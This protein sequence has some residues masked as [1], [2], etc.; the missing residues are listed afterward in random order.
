[1]AIVHRI[2]GELPRIDPTAIRAITLQASPSGAT[3]AIDAV[4]NGEWVADVT[5]HDST[6][7]AL[8]YLKDRTE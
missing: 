3:L 7:S 6:E 8:A 2:S 5:L 4:V 1:M